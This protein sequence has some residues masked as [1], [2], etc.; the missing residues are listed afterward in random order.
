MQFVRNRS[1]A[2]GLAVGAALALG[3]SVRGGSAAPAASPGTRLV[4]LRAYNLKAGGRD[5]FHRLA[6]QSAVPM[7]RRAGIDVVAFGPS[8]HD[9]TSYFLIRSFASLE[10]RQARE[11][12]FY[13]SAEWRDGP[14]D[15]VL[16][17]IES[18]TTVVLELE[19]AAIDGLRRS[20]AKG[21]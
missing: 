2:A 14:R 16:A 17:L 13:G 21:R 10:D 15:A 3:G 4:E 1:V 5:E 6:A 18:Y 11:D 12:A 9:A 20:G 19:P 7:L 8:S